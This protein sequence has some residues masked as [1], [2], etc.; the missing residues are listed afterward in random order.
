MG[1]GILVPSRC[2]VFGKWTA[3]T[4]LT[5]YFYFL[6]VSDRCAVFDYVLQFATSPGAGCIFRFS[7]SFKTGCCPATAAYGRGIIF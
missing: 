6:R 5:G 4:F 3:A 2:H 7:K 1:G